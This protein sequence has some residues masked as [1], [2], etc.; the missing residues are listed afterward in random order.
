[1]VHEMK[2]QSISAALAAVS[3]LMGFAA[4][5]PHVVLG[6]FFSV[7]GGLTAMAVAPM[8]QRM[9][10][11]LAILVSLVIGFFAGLI[12]PHFGSISPLIAW[13]SNLPVQAVMGIAG[14]SS[15]PI[16]RRLASG[17]LPAISRNDGGKS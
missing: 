9:A 4:P 14:L 16:A 2:I 3:A 8:A 15:A 13:V 6:L 7:A 1:M 12:H 5:W 11:P 10:L 17:E